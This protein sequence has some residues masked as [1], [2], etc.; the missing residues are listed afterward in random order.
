MY[1]S[2][3]RM[4]QRI[5]QSE[6]RDLSPEEQLHDL[7]RNHLDALAERYPDLIPRAADFR[8][9]IDEVRKLDP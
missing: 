4:L 6:H 5:V 3:R 8:S 2:A 1:R 7:V 9:R